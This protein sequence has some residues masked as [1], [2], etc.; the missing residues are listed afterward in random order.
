MYA[1][2]AE[3]PKIYSR[4]VGL[5]GAVIAVGGGIVTCA[6][7]VQSRTQL[8]EN[9]APVDHWLSTSFDFELTDSQRSELLAGKKRYGQHRRPEA[10]HPRRQ[11]AR[12]SAHHGR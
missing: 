4:L 6:L 5:V 2:A 11:R 8:G 1:G 10:N 7:I 9:N 3:L 12:W